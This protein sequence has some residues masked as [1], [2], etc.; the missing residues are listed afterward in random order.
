MIDRRPLETFDDRAG[1]RWVNQSVV[2]LMKQ[3]AIDDETPP[4]VIRRL[5]RKMVAEARSQGWTDVPFDAELLAELQGIEVKCATGDIRAEARLMPLPGRRLEIEYAPDAPET[6]RRFSICHEI[7][8]TFFPDCFEQV[9]HRR[10]NDKHDP[11][12]AELEQLC[13]I[14][15][16]ELLMPLEEFTAATAN[17]APSMALAAKLG[18]HFNASPEA[19]LRRLVDLT[20]NAYC[21]LWLSKRLKPKEEKDS[22]PEFDFGFDGPKP[23]LRIDYQFASPSWTVFLPRHKS[24]PDDS[25]LYSVLN[26]E[27][28]EVRSEDWSG[29][30]LSDVRIE[31]TGSRHAE[32]DAKGV[33]VLL[34]FSQNGSEK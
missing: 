14:G 34:K 19:A 18:L 27:T 12:H 17:R 11:V 16:G 30:N 2:A 5:A 28:C 13:H 15:A 22:G 8:H 32:P 6:R 33:M 9:Q 23:K 10:Q 25:I 24:I 20:R 21:L 4:Q 29:L 3:R 26:G 7:A 1:R 31:A